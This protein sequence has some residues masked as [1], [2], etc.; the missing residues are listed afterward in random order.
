MRFEG[1]TRRHDFHPR[2]PAFTSFVDKRR[3][4]YACASENKGSLELHANVCGFARMCMLG[5]VCKV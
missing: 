1:P 3:P 4:A 2:K 5:E